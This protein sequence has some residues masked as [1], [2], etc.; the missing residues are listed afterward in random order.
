MIPGVNQVC[1]SVLGNDLI[2]STASQAG[3]LQLNAFGPVVANAM[4]TSEKWLTAALVTLRVNCIDG[5]TADERRLGEQSSSL[6]GIAT[7]FIP[8]IGY[9]AAGEIAKTAL[10]TGASIADLIVDAGL[11][12]RADVETIME[13][14][15]RHFRAEADATTRRPGTSG[16]GEGGRQFDLKSATVT[17]TTVSPPRDGSQASTSGTAA[18]RDSSARRRAVRSGTTT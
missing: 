1:F 11:M 16:V 14:T 15:T 9:T 3:Q 13:R 5:I 7:A 10:S 2:V 17:A 6:A 12:E 18:K 4:L 8:Y